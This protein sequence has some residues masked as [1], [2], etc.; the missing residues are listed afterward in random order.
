MSYLLRTIKGK[1]WNY[2]PGDFTRI[3]SIPADP[4]SDL[5]TKGE[6]LSFYHIN[7]FKDI[8]EAVIAGYAANRG[9][10]QELQ[11]VIIN[12]EDFLKAGFEIEK[13]E[14]RTPHKD[15]NNAHRQI[16]KLKGYRLIHIAKIIF[17]YINTDDRVKTYSHSEIK[18]IIRGQMENINFDKT[19]LK[20]TMKKELGLMTKCA[21]CGN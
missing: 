9:Y 4:I 7:D 17:R 10:I 8:P 3:R 2:E 20:D 16:E 21:C 18:S 6:T 19:V 12:E 14:G 1:E 13:T 15:A 5:I 11:V